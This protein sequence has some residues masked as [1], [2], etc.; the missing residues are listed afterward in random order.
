MKAALSFDLQFKVEFYQLN[1]RESE[2]CSKL[3]TCHIPVISDHYKEP[4]WYGVFI[5]YSYGK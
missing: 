4:P 1:K 2:S 5:T 3:H